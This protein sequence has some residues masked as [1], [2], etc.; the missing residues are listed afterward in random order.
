MP[1]MMSRAALALAIVAG[2]SRGEAQPS[3]PEL[4]VRAS[5]YVGRFLTAYSNVVADERYEQESTARPRRR[6]LRSELVLVHYPGSPAWQVFRDVLEVD[7]RMVG[8]TR[9]GRLPAL[10]L[11]P[12]EQAL[13][14][15]KEIDAAGAR[16]HIG[17]IGTL[18]NPLLVLA[19]LQREYRE[20]FRFTPTDLD[21]AAGPTVRIVQFEE[22]RVPTILRLGGNLDMPARG[23]LWIDETDGRVLK[24]ELRVGQRDFAHSSMTWRPPSTITTIF[25][26]DEQLGI[27]VPR[28]MRGHYALQ[29]VEIRGVATYTRF[30]RFPVRPATP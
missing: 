14:R 23:L 24:T 18:D 5:A 1:P 4:V 19:F 29:D 2:A 7:G 30:R 16:H 15:A 20:R 12:A 13:P 10:F 26:L 21:R 27:D 28:E 22:V 6:T 17:E 3:Q 8:G 25:G 11:G 9:E